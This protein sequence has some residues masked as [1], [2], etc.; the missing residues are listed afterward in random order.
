M[1]T[2]HID[3]KGAIAHC[4]HPRWVVTVLADQ[5]KAL[6]QSLKRMTDL[7]LIERWCPV[8][9]LGTNLGT[10]ASRPHRAVAVPPWFVCGRDARVP[11]RPALSG[12]AVRAPGSAGGVG[13]AHE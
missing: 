8:A 5:A 11:R 12:G 1:P 3:S 2:K 10:R 9:A 6:G 4:R 7:R 13:V